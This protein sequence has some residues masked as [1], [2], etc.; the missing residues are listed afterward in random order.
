M[1]SAVKDKPAEAGGQKIVVVEERARRETPGAPATQPA[2]LMQALAVAAANPAMDVAKVKELFAMHRELQDREAAQA[3]SDALARAQANI[4]P[5]AKDRRNEHT[6]SMYATLAAIVD[7]G[8]P[9]IT[10]EGLAVSYDMY[11]PGGRD[12]DMPAPVQGWHRVIA[13]VSHRGGH[14]RKYHF[15]GPLDDAGK[16]GTK[17][18][19]GIQAMG[20]TVSYLRRY[21][22]CMI[23]NVATVDDDDGNGSGDA[24]MDEKKLADHLAALDAAADEPSLLK[25]F[26]LA[27]NAAEDVKDKGAQ[28]LL[29]QHRDARKKSIRERGRS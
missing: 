6:K 1:E 10:A 21:L 26:S 22:F 16:D 12:K 27:W 20:S 25:A 23:F 3:F 18:K 7:E 8:T 24:R 14:S 28:R 17:N 19:T 15:D 4:R 9:I 13:I 11:D 2:N 5:I 29:I